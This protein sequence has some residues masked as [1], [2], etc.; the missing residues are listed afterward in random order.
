MPN[1]E[2]VIKKVNLLF[3]RLGEQA[4]FNKGGVCNG[5]SLL[6]IQYCLENKE[7][8]FFS[9]LERI[10]KKSI[11]DLMS[12]SEVY[13]LTQ[14][15]L[16][17]FKPGEFQRGL[18]QFDFPPQMKAEGKPVTS[19]NRWFLS[20]SKES[21][22]SVF[23]TLRKEDRVMHIGS[24]THAVSVRQLEDGSYTLYDPNAAELYV[25]DN[26]SDLMDGLI[27]ALY[28]TKPKDYKENSKPIPM[29][30]TFCTNDNKLREDA[31]P[32]IEEVLEQVAQQD[33][34]SSSKRE[35]LD[36]TLRLTA[37]IDDVEAVDY[38]LNLYDFDGKSLERAVIESIRMNRMLVANQIIRY[39]IQSKKMHIGNMT[40]LL[41]A[42]CIKGN[43]SH[44]EKTIKIID[45]LELGTNATQT[46]RPFQC[47]RKIGEST[48]LELT[49]Y[50][51]KSESINALD[52]WLDIITAATGI[53]CEEWLDKSTTKGNSFLELATE[54]ASVEMVESIREKS[55][56]SQ[57]ISTETQRTH[58]VEV[59]LRNAKHS[60]KLIRYWGEPTV[61]LC[62]QPE[63]IT[64][65]SVKEI[66]A[67]LEVGVTLPTPPQAMLLATTMRGSPTIVEM[68]A[69]KYL[70]MY[71]S[72]KQSGFCEELRDILDYIRGKTET[73]PEESK[74]TL[75][76][77]MHYL[78]SMECEALKDKKVSSFFNS[79]TINTEAKIEVLEMAV[80]LGLEDKVCMI[81]ES[82]PTLSI[83]SSRIIECLREAI[84][85]EDDQVLVC[86]VAVQSND[87]LHKTALSLIKEDNMTPELLALVMP[88]FEK[89]EKQALFDEALAS[90]SYHVFYHL[91]K[92]AKE[93]EPYP[94]DRLKPTVLRA[95]RDEAF[96]KPLK[97]A[98][99][100][101]SIQLQ[102]KQLAEHTRLF[103]SKST[104][105]KVSEPAL[106]KQDLPKP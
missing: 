8:K 50:V 2:I 7:E 62:L 37:R 74:C 28:W 39:G 27:D 46:M 65:H 17:Y 40:E 23:Q 84:V 11:K 6:H 9:V 48:L 35:G 88:H 70:E 55:G 94:R 3:K 20:A 21:W 63:I 78:I 49:E 104:T 22:I 95:Q 68:I 13:Q 106:K 102:T 61:N 103:K 5:L 60:D 47:L 67:L 4:R 29:S 69:E 44:I 14:E 54:H 36:E 101:S 91:L 19:N 81:K 34:W 73:L 58:L 38:L 18:S 42:S 90:R 72:T 1:Q 41:L 31:F 96:K 52:S 30:I 89:S 15:V 83:P 93:V 32:V 82:S 77:P 71:Q 86:A 53:P 98:I 75:L 25:Y 45:E 51:I 64:R 97:K 76:T 10:E 59:S 79:A 87:Q 57:A 66:K 56:K 105:K 43:A 80:R 33:G 16:L 92:Y 99:K 26:E 12:D 85:S 24:D 100:A